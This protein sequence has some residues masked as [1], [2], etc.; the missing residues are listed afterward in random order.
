MN[1]TRYINEDG[2]CNHSHIIEED[3]SDL[4]IYSDGNI[5]QKHA[6]RKGNSLTIIPTGHADTSCKI[7]IS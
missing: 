2:T 4:H 7:S 3:G 1:E 6:L 5:P